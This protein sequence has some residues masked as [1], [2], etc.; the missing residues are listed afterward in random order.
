MKYPTIHILTACAF[1]LGAC[2]HTAQ[3]T[4]MSSN[5][6]AVNDITTLKPNGVIAE[7]VQFKGRS[8][9]KLEMTQAL[10]KAVL[11]GQANANGSSFALTDA[12][13]ENGVIEV[14]VAGEINGKG[15]PDA[16]GFVGIAFHVP[17]DLKTYDMVYLRMSNGSKNNPVPPE[18][19][20]VRAVQYVAHPD[21]HFNV[22]REKF[23]G[24][25]EAAAPVALSTW[26]K[27]RLEI[28]GATA[29]AFV[30]GKK[31]LTVNDLRFPNRKGR[32]ALWVDDGSAGYFSNLKVIL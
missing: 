27:L 12:T 5:Q 17:E 30:D 9:V 15:A 2:T 7:S 10:Q 1:A 16:R 25:Y 31:V 20:N 29:T 24:Q 11:A 14:D 26:H 3:V 32:I 4:S 6:I 18:P 19:R 28:N 13:F 22:S 21:F 8:A 23:P